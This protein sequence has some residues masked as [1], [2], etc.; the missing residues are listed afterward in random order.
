MISCDSRVVFGKRS[1][2]SLCGTVR[3]RRAHNRGRATVRVTFPSQPAVSPRP[4][5]VPAAATS[6]ESSEPL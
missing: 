6:S 2:R 1:S 3:H 5:P 4:L